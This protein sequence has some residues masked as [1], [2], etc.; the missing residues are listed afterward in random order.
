MANNR[1]NDITKIKTQ[2]KVYLTFDIETIVARFSKNNNCYASIC[3]A[4]L[5]IAHYL[6]KRNL[7][8]TFFISLSP[9]TKDIEYGVYSA[10]LEILFY[11]L[12]GFE[13]IKLAPHIHAFSLPMSFPCKTD[14]FDKYTLTQQIDLLKWAKELFSNY[15]YEVDS[16]RPGGYFTNEFYYQALKDAKYKYSSV[17]NR[18]EPPVINLINNDLLTNNPFFV[19]NSVQEYPISSVKIK[20]IKGKEEIINLSPDFLVLNTIKGFLQR[21]EYININFHSFSLLLTKLIRENHNNIFWHNFKYLFFERTLNKILKKLDIYTIYGNTILK[22]ELINY[23]DYFS[24]NDIFSTK[25][26]GEE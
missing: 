11:G 18:A 9:K 5:I 15:G 23:L 10:Y 22:N 12:K 1:T 17:L 20:S 3:L 7:K 21:M 13:N 26:I 16:F 25:F 2:N 8:G 6:K 24:S 19:N 14:R 4:P